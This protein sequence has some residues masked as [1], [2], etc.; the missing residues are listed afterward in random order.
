MPHVPS[1]L[2]FLYKKKNVLSELI[3]Y[4]KRGVQYK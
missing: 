4:K 1:N 2:S 3:Q